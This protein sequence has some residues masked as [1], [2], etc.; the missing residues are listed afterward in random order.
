VRAGYHPIS[1]TGA[2]SAFMGQAWGYQMWL[3]T[4]RCLRL[5]DNIPMIG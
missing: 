2:I 5:L 3:D 1:T 4:L